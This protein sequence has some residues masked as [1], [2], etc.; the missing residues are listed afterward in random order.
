MAQG[1][2]GSGG[3][4]RFL[5]VDNEVG[6]PQGCHPVVAQH[7][8]INETRLPQELSE[9]ALL[10]NKSPLEPQGGQVVIGFIAVVP[11]VRSR[12]VTRTSTSL[13]NQWLPPL[14]E[15]TNPVRVGIY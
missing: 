10:A 6:I 7:W 1:R 4:I 3:L 2:N 5:P 15:V 8:Q 9:T 11:C 13:L 12:P 14:S